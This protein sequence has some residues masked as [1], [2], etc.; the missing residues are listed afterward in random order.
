MTEQEHQIQNVYP[1]DYT[2]SSCYVQKMNGYCPSEEC[3]G[4]NL[5]Y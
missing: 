2:F 1:K 3:T 5:Y 4:C